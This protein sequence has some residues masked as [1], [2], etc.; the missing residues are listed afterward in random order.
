MEDLFIKLVNVSIMA[1]KIVL[2]V[3][4]LRILFQKA[5]KWIHCLLWG[6]AGA[7]L[8]L[9][10]SIQSPLSMIAGTA[11]I[12]EDMALMSEPRIDSGIEVVDRMVDPYVIAAFSPKPWASANPL[13]ILFAIVSVIWLAGVVAIL[14]YGAVSYIVLRLRV[15]A[16]VALRE[17]IYLCDHIKTPFVLGFL[18]PRIYLPSGLAEQEQIYVIRHEQ[19][20]LKRG[21]HLFKALGFLLLAVYWF[22]PFVWLAYIL[23]CRDVEKACDE[24]VIKNLGGEEKREYAKA[25]LSCSM[26]KRRMLV[27]PLAF[28]EIG[29]KA[30]I[31]AVA[32]YKKPS[33]RLVVAAVLAC[34]LL[35]GCFLT[36][37]QKDAL[38]KEEQEL[39]ILDEHREEGA[40]FYYPSNGKPLRYAVF[41][42]DELALF[43]EM[44][45]KIEWIHNAIADRIFPE[46]YDCKIWYQ[47]EWIYV[48][49]ETCLF[50]RR[51]YF[52]TVP[53]GVIAHLKYKEEQAKDYEALLE[54]SK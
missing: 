17:N 39:T 14:L 31:K 12:P 15:R 1:N 13:Q 42:K 34:L 8:L 29:V 45:D 26:G 40:I 10:F 43:S 30:R 41:T 37:P 19:A 5:P 9:P 54:K 23:F 52:S 7:R 50:D 20:H 44:Y 3:L 49:Y 48:D 46:H 6:I 25:L 51:D 2:A 47:G 11:T 21:D 28:S 35:T 32:R 27:C 24:R 18:K 4:L 36:D 16:S 38:S 53:D 33:A 22:D